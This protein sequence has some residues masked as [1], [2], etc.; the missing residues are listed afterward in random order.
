MRYTDVQIEKAIAEAKK[1]IEKFPNFNL[2]FALETSCI[3]PK[4]TKAQQKKII[5]ELLSKEFYDDQ[6]PQEPR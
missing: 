1:A 3:W 6:L 4:L 5:N 2:A